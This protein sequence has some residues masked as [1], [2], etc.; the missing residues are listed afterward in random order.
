[1]RATFLRDLL[2]LFERD[3]HEG[4]ALVQRRGSR[5]K[6]C[7]RLANRR[8]WLR[9]APEKRLD[10]ARLQRRLP[11]LE[12]RALLHLL[13]VV[14]HERLYL[15]FKPIP[16]VIEI[17]MLEQLLGRRTLLRVHAQALTSE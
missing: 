10:S 8:H 16:K 13:L 12:P 11:L 7:V 4:S 9:G 2:T 6:L 14:F 5:S 17:I 3:G 15:I 1:M